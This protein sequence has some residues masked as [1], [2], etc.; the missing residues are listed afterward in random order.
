M[1]RMNAL[2]QAIFEGMAHN[3][4]DWYLPGD[5]RAI[6]DMF[7]ETYRAERKHPTPERPK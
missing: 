4:Y 1:F 3:L 2:T 7:T 5:I 6:D